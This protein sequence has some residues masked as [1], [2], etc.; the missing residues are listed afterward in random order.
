MKKRKEIS[1]IEES[2]LKDSI[3]CLE[4]ITVRVANEEDLNNALQFCTQVAE[5]VAIG[6]TVN[7]SIYRSTGYGSDLSVHICRPPESSGKEKS[8]IGLSLAMDL[9]SFGIVNHTL[10][11]K[12]N[13]GAGNDV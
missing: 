4:V 5:T 9:N 2:R 11:I 8:L 7:M 3:S 12:Q 13:I 1:S 10:W 6:E